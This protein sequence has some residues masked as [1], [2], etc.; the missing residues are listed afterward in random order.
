MQHCFVYV[1]LNVLEKTWKNVVSVYNL[2]NTFVG[3]DRM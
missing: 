1:N 2:C 3:V